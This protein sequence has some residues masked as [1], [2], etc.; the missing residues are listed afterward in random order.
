MFMRFV[1]NEVSLKGEQLL[2]FVCYMTPPTVYWW[3]YVCAQFANSCYLTINKINT[4]VN[5]L[6]VCWTV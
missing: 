3:F 5:R 4:Q 1:K 6:L 2:F